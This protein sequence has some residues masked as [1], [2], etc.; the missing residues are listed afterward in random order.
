MRKGPSG[1]FEPCHEVSTESD[2]H[3]G[4]QVS[5]LDRREI[6]T[7]LWN[8]THTR[9]LL[10]RSTVSIA[11]GSNRRSFPHDETAMR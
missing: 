8:G 9:G 11:T 1:S 7:L 5:L 2:R 4:L 10:D 6:L 3:P